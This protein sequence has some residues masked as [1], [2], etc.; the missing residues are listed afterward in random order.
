MFARCR[1]GGV[2]GVLR[3]VRIRRVC[4]HISVYSYFGDEAERYLPMESAISVEELE[5][6][7]SGLLAVYFCR[8]SCHDIY[9]DLNGAL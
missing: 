3:W 8:W 2:V 4:R 5:V 1:F 9:R 7:R 6:K